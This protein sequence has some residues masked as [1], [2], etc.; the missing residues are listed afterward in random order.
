MKIVRI[1]A[2]DDI[3]NGAYDKASQTVFINA[4]LLDRP[5]KASL[6]VEA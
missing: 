6:M 3:N 4:K 1:K 2:G 5:K